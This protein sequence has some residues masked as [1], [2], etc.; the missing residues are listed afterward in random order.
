[1]GTEDAKVNT[2]SIAQKAIAL[3]SALLKI[4]SLIAALYF[5]SISVA[6]LLT[7]NIF[8]YWTG[9][10]LLCS[11]ALAGWMILYA[12]LLRLGGGVMIFLNDL[13]IFWFLV[14]AV[15][16]STTL[17]YPSPQRYIAIFVWVLI[18]AA[19]HI[20]VP[21]FLNP[22]RLVRLILRTRNKGSAEPN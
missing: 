10:F 22:R 14:F 6:S 4:L 18:L 1:M 2:L 13:L 9:C 17:R 11:T 12:G 20:A 7:K 15:F 5:V 8:H 16:V 19:F 21:G 3:A